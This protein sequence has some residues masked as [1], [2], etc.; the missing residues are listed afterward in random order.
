MLSN[1][2]WSC[3]RLALRPSD[4]LDAI[5]T[6]STARLDTFDPQAV[7][8]ICWSFA[9]LGHRPP[10]GFLQA[11][12]SHM[13]TNFAEYSSQGIALVLFG[14]AMQGYTSEDLLDSVAHE[15]EICGLQFSP[16]DLAVV[17]AA[18]AMMKGRNSKAVV[19]LVLQ[20]VLDNV[21]KFEQ[22]PG[23]LCSIMWSIAQLRMS[24]AKCVSPFTITNLIYCLAFGI[25]A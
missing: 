1:V 3:A 18:F 15:I 19:S 11:A 4:L 6:E 21:A 5:A 13:K 14:L 7:A 12:E 24:S 16:H 9:K 17:I 23:L 25:H 2:A 22:S 8:L 20:Q 10:T